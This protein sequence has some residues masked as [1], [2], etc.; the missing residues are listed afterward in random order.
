MKTTPLWLP[1]LLVVAMAAV[2]VSG[3]LLV[4]SALLFRLEWP[5]P[6]RL[7]GGA[8]NLVGAVHVLVG[9][10]LAALMGTIWA[11]H[12]RPRWR[13]RHNRRSGLG[14]I[15]VLVVLGLTGIGCM[16]LGGE[17]AAPLNSL[18]HMVLGLAAPAVIALHMARGGGGRRS[19]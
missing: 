14:V 17:F 11:V 8:R 13:H 6:W 15:V 9:F 16:Y 12:I 18:G 7:G 19:P 1:R 4:P 3:S 2:V 10:G 5:V